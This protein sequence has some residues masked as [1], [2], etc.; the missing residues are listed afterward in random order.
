MR[1]NLKKFL[2]I[3]L[4]VNIFLFILSCLNLENGE[5]AKFIFWAYPLGAFIWEDL[6]IFSLFNIVA[7][8]FVCLVKDLRYM[9]VIPLCFWLVRA[10]GETFYWFLQ[11]FNQPA[12]YP[13]NEYIWEENEWIRAL[14]GEFPNQK[15][16]I[17]YQVSWQVVTVICLV[18]LVYMFANWKQIG[19]KVNKT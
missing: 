14:V 16:F 3:W 19:E 17:L 12:K 1:T 18:G 13:H 2:V 11:Q 4:I 10:I 15:F 9:I 6:V 5:E 8:I 7:T